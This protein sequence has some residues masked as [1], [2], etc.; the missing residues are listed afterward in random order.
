MLFYFFFLLTVFSFLQDSL[1]TISLRKRQFWQASRNTK[2]K[3]S[4]FLFFY[5]CFLF[6]YSFF[7]LLTF[8]FFQVFRNA[9]YY[10]IMA[11]NIPALRHYGRITALQPNYGIT[12]ELRHY[13]KCRNR[14]AVCRNITVSAN[15][16]RLTSLYPSISSWSFSYSIAYHSHKNLHKLQGITTPIFKGV[17]I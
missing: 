7:L 9:D 13:G 5:L 12:A 10:S 2:H 11:F 8:T 14:N 1:G 15:Q 3:I 4:D 16:L 6:F 17:S